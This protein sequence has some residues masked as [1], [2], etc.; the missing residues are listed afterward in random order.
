MLFRS[1]CLGVESAQNF[2]WVADTY[3]HKIKLVSPHSGNCQTILGVVA[4][5]HDAQGQN[6]CFNEPS[7]LSI[8]GAYLY[9]AD[10]NNHAIK[11]VALDTLTV[12]TMEF[13]GLCAP[14]VCIP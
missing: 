4:G 14:D 3:N 9:V 13:S 12:N 1:H 10:T 11:R 2:L 6:S 8:F 7:G 5:L